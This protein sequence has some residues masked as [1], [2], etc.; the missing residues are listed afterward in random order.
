MGNFIRVAGFA[1]LWQGEMRA[2]RLG[3]AALLLLKCGNEVRAYADRCPHLGVPLSQG[4]LQGTTLTC[5]AHCW[6]FDAVSGTGINPAAA[7]LRSFPVKIVA[8]D[9]LVDYGC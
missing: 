3:E 4:T 2:L 8:D 7:K 9:V 5:S 1:D 6:Q